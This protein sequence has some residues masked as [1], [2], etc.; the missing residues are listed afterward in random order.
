MTKKTL[1]DGKDF[2]IT[3]KFKKKGTITC[4]VTSGSVKITLNGGAS[5]TYGGNQGLAS[6]FKKTKDK[7][8][9]EWTVKVE[10]NDDKAG[11]NF[12]APD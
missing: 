3:H 6:P 12:N 4:Q 8:N 2:P 9:Q 1:K 7:S 11:V 5:N 10:K